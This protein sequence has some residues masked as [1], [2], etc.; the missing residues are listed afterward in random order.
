M[1]RLYLSKCRY[2][3][4]LVFMA[5]SMAM[6]QQVVTGTVTSADDG[7]PIPGVNILEKG[8]TNGTVTDV[9]GTFRISVGSSATLSLSFVGYTTT[10][11]AV[12]AQTVVNVSLQ[13]DVTSLSEVV[14][15]GYGT[16]QKK[17][18]TGAVSQVSSKD[19]NAGV[20]VNPLQAIQGKV[21]GLNITQGSG[22][23]N[24]TPT[25]RLRGYT[26]MLGGSDPLYVVDG[27][28]GVPITSISPND[29]ETIDVLKD[30]SAA[31]IYGS[32]GAN[33]VIIITTK[34]GKSGKTTVTF[35]NYISMATISKRLD[36]LDADGYR[37]QVSRIKGDAA[38]GD[39]QRFPKDA[40]G[41][42][43]NTDWMKE[44]TRT[45]AIHN[46]E[47]ALMGGT[48]QLSYR[49]SVNY[50]GQEGIV[51]NTGLDRVTGRFNL[52]Q[53]ALNN[54]LSIQYNLSFMNSK[55]Q[56]ANADILTRATTFLPT[57]PVY[58]ADGSFYE[59]GG[60]FD[61][62]NPVAMQKNYH[63][64]EVNKVF[65]GGLNLKY[66]I[67]PGLTV[68]AN[69]AFKNDNTINSQAYNGAIKA[70]TSNSGNTTKNLYQ[71][72]NV[73]LELT[74]NYT[75]NFGTN[76]KFSLLG[77]YSYQDNIDDGF[78]A[79]NNN[80]V[81]GFYDLFGY[82]NLGLGRATLLNGSS[83]YV[84]SY[85]SEW[86]L[87][88]FF[89]RGTLD[90]NDRFNFTG[91]VRRDGSSKFGAN[92]KWGV[93]P[94]VSGG[95]TLS[96]EQFLAGNSTLSMLKLR[97]GWGQTGNS[98][99]IFPYRSLGLY[100]SQGTYY[101][102]TVGDFLPGYGP[103]Q[104][105]NQNLKWEVLEQ[106]NIGLDF[107]LFGGKVQGTLEAYNKVT[108]GMLFN[109]GVGVGGDNPDYPGHQY[110][111]GTILRN[112]GS[113]SNKGIELSIGMSPV[114]TS[115]FTWNTRVV[116]AAYKNT[117]TSISAPG[118][119]PPT[120]LYNA[121]GG[122]GLSNVFA[123][124]L[125]EGR[126]LGQFRI[127]QFAGF[128]T[129]GNVTLV[130]ADGG[131]P[132]TDYT[133][134]LLYYAGHSQPNVTASWI[135]SFTYKR[136]DLSLQLR[137]VF[138]NSIMNNLRSN[139]AIP[140]SI[141]ETNMLKAVGDYP[142]NYS[143]NQLSNLWIEKGSF[144]RLDNWQIGYNIPVGNTLLTNARVYVSGNNLFIIT[145]YKGVDPELEVKGDLPTGNDPNTNTPNSMGMDNSGIYPKTRTFMLGVN[146]TF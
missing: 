91:T 2:T 109:Y 79:N 51:K 31:A 60:S 129:N 27:V 104:N 22:D 53:K 127:P 13:P 59:V 95:W 115:D 86:K 96:N 24:A 69:G 108:K 133:K 4:L 114:R 90:L 29:I 84:S 89:A 3:I 30:A 126:P 78:G 57:L 65:V 72:N 52:D 81:A 97:V 35:N 113:M 49:A 38:F 37:E 140:G 70:Y 23:P 110:V 6:A 82:N 34:R 144:V 33:G 105:T 73:L 106:T 141:L 74:A 119:E 62:F 143:T 66:E 58:N 122:R 120:I 121:F 32:R 11:V 98:E 41:N 138:G 14:V 9:D 94:S 103:S 118:V 99:G 123:S 132:V 111:V 44:V 128:D 20:N 80:Y 43:Y 137:G 130:A 12:G 77:G 85:K 71:T 142:V 68:G 25:V 87:I 124:K 1:I 18:L 56:L 5:T 17:D 8:T 83:G 134:A 136:F 76:S 28:I 40:Q 112:A 64:D 145:K 88:S 47:L 15:V 63:N 139:L 19:F 61:L 93:F 146:L 101:D 45:A 117:I 100:G 92:N 36:L 16:V 54:K 50:I 42:G 39:L 75:K 107:E 21:A 55:K 67:L 102:G 135:N 10:E 125:E 131:A 7:S 26:S 46:H 48:D 116:G